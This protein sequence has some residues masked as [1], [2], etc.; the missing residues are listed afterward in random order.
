[1]FCVVLFYEIKGTNDYTVVFDHPDQRR[2]TP[3]L[4]HPAG[5]SRAR[6]RI[7]QAGMMTLTN[8]TPDERQS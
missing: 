4:H 2:A 6:S 7:G 8:P 5:T 3:A 1:M